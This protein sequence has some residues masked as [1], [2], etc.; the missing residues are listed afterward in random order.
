[1]SRMTHCSSCDRKSHTYKRNCTACGKDKTHTDL[2][3]KSIDCGLTDDNR[4]EIAGLGVVV[5]LFMTLGL[6]IAITVAT[7]G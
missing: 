5:A 7:F 2:P 4:N 6:V 3:V 1:M